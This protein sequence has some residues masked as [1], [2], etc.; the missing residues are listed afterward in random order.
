MKASF[1]HVKI[2]VSDPS[3]Y[4]DLLTYLGFELGKVYAHGFG[5]KSDGIGVWVFKTPKKY[6]RGF[7]FQATGLNHLAFHV[8]SN[9]EVDKF[10]SGYLLAKD[11]PIMHEPKEYTEYNQGRG[12]YAVFFQ[13]PHGMKLEVNHKAS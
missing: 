3:F 12:Y 10:Y 2:N 11:I 13:D 7:N 4:K 5:A 8:S 1:D 9:D 6:E